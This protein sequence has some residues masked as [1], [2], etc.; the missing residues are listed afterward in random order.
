[1]RR[2]LWASYSMYFL[3]GISSV[4]FGAILPELLRY[5]HTTY[6]AGGILILLQAIGF[7]IGVP[8]TTTCMKHVHYRFILSGAAGAVAIAQTCLLFLPPFHVLEAVVILSG[9]GTSALETAV[10]SYVMELYEGRRAIFMS[11]LEVSFGLGA[12]C[13]PAVASV[14]IALNGWRFTAMLA[15]G[16]ALILVFVWQTISVDLKDSD[17]DPTQKDAVLTAAPVFK[18]K[19]PKYSVL[20]LFLLMIFVYVG[21]E[22]SLNSFLPSIFVVHLKTTPYIASLSASVFWGA[23]VCG[24]LMIGWIVQRVNYERY[25]FSSIGIGLFFL[26]MLAL[27]KSSSLS[28]LIVFGL[29]L[30]FSAIYSITMVY[31]NHTFPGMERLVTSSVTAFAGIGSAVFPAIIG[32]VMDH[33]LPSQILWI[34]FGFT[35]LLLIFFSLIFLS[36][37]FLAQ[38]NS[39][40]VKRIG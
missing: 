23:M 39:R 7:I 27:S 13:F 26:L 5:Y 6:T 10:A 3:G 14:L 1:M 29:G 9:V 15:G 11:R 30:G 21:I 38:L 40:P 31:A 24:R 20:M 8:I 12:F 16:F 32:Y 22:G 19:F 37:R 25:L 34:V 2:F 33:F 4:Y 36:L 17:Q 18:R 28:Y 35:L